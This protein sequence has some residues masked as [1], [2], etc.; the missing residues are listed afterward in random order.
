MSSSSASAWS[1]KSIVDATITERKGQTMLNNSLG[2]SHSIA[3]LDTNQRFGDI[4]EVVNRGTSPIVLAAGDTAAAAKDRFLTAATIP[5]SGRVRLFYNGTA[6][7]PYTEGGLPKYGTAVTAAA[8]IT[9]T[10]E[11]FHVTGNTNI[12]SMVGTNIAPGTVIKIIFDGTPTFTDGSNLKIAGNLVA[13]AD[14]TI[15]CVWDGSNFYE[16]ARAVN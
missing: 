9:P 4:Q 12:T 8:A 13:T 11:T 14:D 2:A 15:T 16:I 5:P 1:G 7:E 3:G 6:W 10:G